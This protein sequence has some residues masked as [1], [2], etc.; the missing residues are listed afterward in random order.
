MQP[1]RSHRSPRGQA[2]LLIALGIV[3]LIGL[4]AITI[5]GGNAYSE[6]RH[7]Q[8]AADTTVLAA[9]LAK[10]RNEDWHGV[11]LQRASSNGYDNNGTTNTV[12]LYN[13]DDPA[14]SCG[15]YQGNPEYVQAII[16]ATIDTYFAPVV[17]IRQL[18][19]R[20]NAVAR[21]APPKSDQMFNGQA[22]VGLAPHDCQA[23]KYQ[24]NASTSIPYGG[25]FV[26]S[27]CADSAF[28]NHSGSAQL[29]TPSLCAVGGIEVDPGAL[30]PGTVVTT[31]CQSVGY[32]PPGIIEPD[33]ICT[34]NALKVGTTLTA[35]T[36]TGT[37]PPAGVTN[38]QSGIFC[39]N[40]DFDLG[41]TDSLTGHDVVIRVNGGHDVRWNAGAVVNLTAPTSG[42]FQGLLLL[43]PLPS[44]PSTCSNSTVRLNGHSSSHIV[45]TIMAMC[46]DVIVE[47]TG[48]SGIFGQI[49]GYTVELTGTSNNSI[50]YDNAQNYDAMQPGS[51]EGT[52]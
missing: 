31:G 1:K 11:G 30:A 24:G 14:A 38:L 32:P 5:D 33:P 23:V 36:F 16:G 29:S 44:D 25:I 6:K 41:S 46:S 40:G 8:N 26:N 20:V 4:T 35:G 10:V 27:D 50:I 49:I 9:A 43:L 48:S 51:V 19:I 18:H 37:F 2:L 52:E 45:G 7:A 28:F 13:C 22:V 15:F 34:G 21:A 39:V 47:G 12:V 42:P 3:A 17:G